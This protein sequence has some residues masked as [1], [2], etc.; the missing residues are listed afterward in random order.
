MYFS[1]D[2]HN[3]LF[4]QMLNQKKIQMIHFRTADPMIP[5]NADHIGFEGKEQLV[6]PVATS[7]RGRCR[8]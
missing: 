2:E 6:P 8:C 7:G 1:G 4:F 5:V 3:S